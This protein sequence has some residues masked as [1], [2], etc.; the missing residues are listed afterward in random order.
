M[1]KS[2][3]PAKLL[4]KLFLVAEAVVETITDLC[5]YY[6]PACMNCRGIDCLNKLRI[7]DTDEDVLG[8]D[9]SNISEYSREK[10][11]QNIAQE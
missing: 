9:V 11:R 2:L 1:T 6:S 7:I 5:L 10:I 3:T 8:I 4:L